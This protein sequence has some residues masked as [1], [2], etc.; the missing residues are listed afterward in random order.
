[1]DEMQELAARLSEANREAIRDGS[2]C[3]FGNPHCVCNAANVAAFVD[4]GLAELQEVSGLPLTDLGRRLQAH[5]T[6]NNGG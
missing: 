4:L 1:M 5:L 2:C 6:N 3:Y